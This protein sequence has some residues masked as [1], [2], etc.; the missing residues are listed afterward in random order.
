MK[1]NEFEELKLRIINKLYRRG[2]IGIPLDFEDFL[3]INPGISRNDLYKA[4][5][6]LYNEGILKRWPSNR[7]SF[8]RWALN[9]HAKNLW[10]DKILKNI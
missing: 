8:D 6:R 2:Y 3:K 4:L 9:P 10:E 7:S 1:K 5:K